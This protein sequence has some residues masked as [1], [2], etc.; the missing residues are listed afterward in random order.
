MTAHIP[1]LSLSDVETPQFVS[2]IGEAYEHYG[3]VIIENHGI[4]QEL[5][6]RFLRQFKTFFAWTESEKQRFHLKGFAV[7][8]NPS[9]LLEFL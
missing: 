8:V 2:A 4:P 6:D 3:F 7:G 5:I 9:H 1:T